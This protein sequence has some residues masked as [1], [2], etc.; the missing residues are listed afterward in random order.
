MTFGICPPRARQI[1]LGHVSSASKSFRRA[2]P[3]VFHSIKPRRRANRDLELLAC[4]DARKCL[5]REFI[6]WH[7]K[8]ANARQIR[9][10]PGIVQL[11]LDGGRHDFDDAQAHAFVIVCRNIYVAIELQP[12]G[13]QE[14][15]QRGFGRAVPGTPR[16]GHDSQIGRG[17]DHRSGLGAGDGLEMRQEMGNGVDRGDIVCGDFS[18]EQ[19]E[20]N[21]IWLGKVEPALHACVE[22]HAVQVGMLLDRAGFV[23][24]TMRE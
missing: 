21:T 24:V 20:I 5:L 1:L 14:R 12:Q 22:N 17:D 19:L 7:T 13:D 18:A 8:V 23:L 9:L 15:M 4:N 11:G 3:P 16:H 2:E 6:E 10:M